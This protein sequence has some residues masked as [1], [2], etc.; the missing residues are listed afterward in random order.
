V[1]PPILMLVTTLTI[2]VSFAQPQNDRALDLNAPLAETLA[3]L[4]A[5][6][7]YVY[8]QPQN[9]QRGQL[10]R[11]A[12]SHIQTRG[13][14]LSYE[15][16]SQALNTGPP[17]S[18]DDNDVREGFEQQR[19]KVD[20]AGLNPRMIRFEASSQQDRPPRIMFGSFDFNDPEIASRLQ[21][22]KVTVITDYQ[23]KAIW[24]SDRMGSYPVREGFVSRSAFPVRDQAKGEE[25][26]VA[27]K[28][29][30]Q[31]CRQAK[32]GKSGP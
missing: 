8:T 3:W 12:V 6:I 26:V 7:P 19:W 2:S 10:R 22:N 21:T 16:T 15:I 29:A 28:H 20:L 25:I 9:S 18:A 1:K 30:V 24:H 11:E 4:K 31:L 17:G 23:G 27:F 32:A 5:K 13:C 14:V